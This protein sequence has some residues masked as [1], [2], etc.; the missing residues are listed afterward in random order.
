[1]DLPS[2]ALALPMLGMMFLTLLVWLC[3]FVQRVG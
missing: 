2:A 1:M 3:M